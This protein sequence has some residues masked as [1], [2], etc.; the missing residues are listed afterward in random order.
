MHREGPLGREQEKM[1][2]VPFLPDLSMFHVGRIIP[3]SKVSIPDF[4]SDQLRK[5]AQVQ[6]RVAYRTSECRYLQ[7]TLPSS[8]C[9]RT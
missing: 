9:V 1:L 4:V 3:T 2:S 5:T 6:D 7:G 8:S